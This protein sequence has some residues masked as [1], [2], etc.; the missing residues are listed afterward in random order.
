M[1]F[2]S[3]DY[4]KPSTL[5]N[6]IT[7]LESDISA[8]KLAFN[9]VNMTPRSGKR[10][11]KKYR[12]KIIVRTGLTDKADIRGKE[13]LTQDSYF[14]DTLSLLYPERYYCRLNRQKPPTLR[15]D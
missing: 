4:S 14:C 3:S 11:K 1:S 7:V 5:T 10:V 15:G 2:E 8:D 9:Y 6:M 12:K 13:S